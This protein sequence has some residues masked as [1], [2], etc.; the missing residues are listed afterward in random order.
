M[1]RSDYSRWFNDMMRY[2]QYSVEAEGLMIVNTGEKALK[3]LTFREARA[4][5]PSSVVAM[6]STNVTYS[7]ASGELL[8]SLDLLPGQSVLVKMNS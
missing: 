3:G 1:A 2:V 5:S 4:A 6:P 7:Y 8:F